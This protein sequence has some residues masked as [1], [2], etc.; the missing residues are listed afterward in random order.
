MRWHRSLA[1]DTDALTIILLHGMDIRNHIK[2]IQIFNNS[3]HFNM[4][5]LADQQHMAALSSQLHGSIMCSPDKRTGSV[6]QLL[7]TQFQT[8]TFLVTHSVCRNQNDRSIR[9][10]LSI[11][12][13]GLREACNIQLMNHTGI[14]NQFTMN[15]DLRRIRHPIGDFQSIPHAKA[16]SHV[17]SSNDFHAVV[18]VDNLQCNNSDFG[19]FVPRQIHE[20]KP[21]TPVQA[22][23]QPPDN[24]VSAALDFLTAGF[25]SA[26]TRS[27]TVMYSV[28]LVRPSSVSRY[29]V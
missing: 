7:A 10:F 17:S 2:G 28:N 15:R 26:T 21:G 12:F 24:F 1:D 11:H 27:K 20:G 18:L 4:P 3:L 16:H 8:G 23:D 22:E 19:S 9:H 13:R 25:P 14:V 5:R 29:M 6:N